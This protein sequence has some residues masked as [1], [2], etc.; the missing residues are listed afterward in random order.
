MTTATKPILALTTSDLMSPEVITIPQELSLRRAAE[1]LFR[2]RIS[3]APVVDTEGRCVG[4]LCATD[5]VQ[6]V[7]EGGQGADEV[8]L[9]ACPY[10][11]KERL[12]TGGEAVVC[13]LAEGSCSLQEMQP[14]TG[15]R[16][17]A[18]CLQPSIV[19]SD[20][21]QITRKL[22]TSAVR[23][24]MSPAIVTVGPETPLPELARTMN[25]AQVHRLFVVDDQRRP[26]GVV[27]STDIIAALAS[28]ATMP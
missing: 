22:P 20:W 25:D 11:I 9:V 26:V 13:T 8:P 28:L 17:A 5:F 2:N 10:Q 23:R 3:G 21:Q 19:A 7:E 6:W 18:V 1:V 16:R 12:P 27:S 4:V 15:G 14:T 24:Y